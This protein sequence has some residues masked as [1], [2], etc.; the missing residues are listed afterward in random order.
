M[1][2]DDYLEAR[3]MRD[4]LVKI[5]RKKHTANSVKALEQQNVAREALI[6]VGWDWTR[7]QPASEIAHEIAARG[8]GGASGEGFG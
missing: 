7:D 6:R 4:A 3:M 5:A 2:W 8:A 1:E